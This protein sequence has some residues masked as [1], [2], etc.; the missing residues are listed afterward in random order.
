LDNAK[1]YLTGSYALRFSSSSKIADILLWL[2][3]E[4]LG[5]DYIDKR[6]QL[7]DSITLDDIK[8]VSKAIKPDDLIITIVGHPEG[9]LP[10]GE[11][12]P[13][14]IPIPRG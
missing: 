7:I 12:T 8:R 13:T 6:N 11:R 4:G 1:R 10:A 2:H 9:L 3:I 5:I 14:A